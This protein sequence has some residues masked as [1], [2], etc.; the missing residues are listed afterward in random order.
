MFNRFKPEEIRKGLQTQSALERM[1]QLPNV[2][3]GPNVSIDR[4]TIIPPNQEINLNII[5]NKRNLP[6]T[7]IDQGILGCIN[8]SVRSFLAQSGI[9]IIFHKNNLT[10]EMAVAIERGEEI[11]FPVRVYNYGLRAIEIEGEVL[12][13]FWV[14]RRTQLTGD[15]LRAIIGKEL[16]IDGEEG[17]DWY[18]GDKGWEW[19]DSKERFPARPGEEFCVIV[20]IGEKRFYVPEA[21]EPFSPR[22]NRDRLAGILEPIPPE[23]KDLCFQI[24]ETPRIYLNEGYTAVILTGGYQHGAKHI[25]S[26]LIDGGSDWPIRTE[27]LGLDFIELAVYKNPEG[28][29]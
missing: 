8:Y 10:D 27:T 3:I 13:F 25:H 5:L 9:D 23:F 7:T 29:I 22:T 17:K 14:D 1:Q 16:I 2:W 12:R 19:K 18:I 15:N 26:S 20:S 4:K 24:S 11:A 21:E 28:N 6:P